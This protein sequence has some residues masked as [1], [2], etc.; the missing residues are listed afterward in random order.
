MTFNKMDNHWLLDVGCVLREFPVLKFLE[1]SS[2]LFNV[3]FI[4][5]GS[6]IAPILLIYMFLFTRFWFLPLLYTIW[7]YI[8]RD[9]G[10]TG[11]RKL[12][13][14]RNL[15]LF[16]YFRD[17]FPIKLI[18]TADL[19][20]DRNYLLVMYPHGIIGYSVLAN[21]GSNANNFDH[22][23][24]GIDTRQVTLN[25]NFHSP[26]TREYL[27][28]L[29]GCAASESSLLCQLNSKPAKAIVLVA[30]GAQESLL[31]HPGTYKIVINNRKGFIRIAL[32]SGASIVPII[33]FGEN[34]A[35]YQLRSKWWTRVQKFFH[36]YTR[37]VPIIPI[38]IAPM[39]RPINTVVGAPINTPKVECPSPEL[40]DEYHEKFKCELLTLFNKYKGTYEVTSGEKAVLEMY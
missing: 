25:S 16:H 17:Y 33:S 38:P 27:L 37:I 26:F 15:K 18:K 22:L 13:F 7:I 19:P 39:R 14:L 2:V 40:I 20:A 35:H 10:F 5:V 21:F 28:F 8:D 4:I 6:T 9:A 24:P 30:G 23:Y 31:A 34:D 29:G 3:F 1:A 12:Y 32:K 11:D 36:R